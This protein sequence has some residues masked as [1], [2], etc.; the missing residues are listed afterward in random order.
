MELMEKGSLDLYIHK[1]TRP[2]KFVNYYKI[3]IGICKALVYLH[4]TIVHRDIK[5]QNILLSKCGTVKLTDFGLSK[6]KETN[7]VASSNASGTPNYVAPEV[8][9][10]EHQAGPKCDIYAV[11]ILMQEMY[12]R[13]RPWQGVKDFQI[14]Y[15]IMM[16]QRPQ[17]PESCPSELAE[18][19]HRCWA[20]NPKDRPT[21]QQLYQWS[22]KQLQIETDREKPVLLYKQK[23]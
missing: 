11:G 9:T 3:L 13:Q 2:I 5:P 8:L 18:M 6:F 16:E 1:N 21:A 15:C 12:T 4:P 14:A 20:Q 7:T 23:Y 10:G 17:I 22:K 19:I